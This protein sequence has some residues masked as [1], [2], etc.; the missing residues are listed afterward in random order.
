MRSTGG[1]SRISP[2]PYRP[3]S[4]MKKG[5]LPPSR[6]GMAASGKK[7]FFHTVGAMTLQNT[8][9]GAHHS[10][11]GG[12]SHIH[13]HHNHDHFELES[14]TSISMKNSYIIKNADPSFEAYYNAMKKRNKLMGIGHGEHSYTP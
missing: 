4:T 5:K 12:H 6:A 10:T 2:S 8:L 1:F 3:T 7:E 13:D 11:M 14:P 9:G